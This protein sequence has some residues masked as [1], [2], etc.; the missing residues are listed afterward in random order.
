MN[1]ERSLFS[2]DCSS[3]PTILFI[4][5]TIEEVALKIRN[6]LKPNPFEC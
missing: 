4:D 3:D 6:L 5:G 2:P 1:I